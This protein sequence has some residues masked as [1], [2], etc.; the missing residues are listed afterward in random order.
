[1]K[2]ILGNDGGPFVAGD[3]IQRSACDSYQF[4]NVSL[5][6]VVLFVELH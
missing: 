5:V 2:N 4:R 3:S 1:M 6:F